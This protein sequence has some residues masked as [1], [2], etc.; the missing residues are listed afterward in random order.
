MYQPGTD[1]ALMLPGWFGPNS[2]TG[3]TCANVPRSA[4]V[5][6]VNQNMTTETGVIT[7]RPRQAQQREQRD[8]H[9]RQHRHVQP[10]GPRDDHVSGEVPAEGAEHQVGADDRD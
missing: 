3:L 6:Q 4:R 2:Q 7:G 8:H 10:V 5:A 9:H 1:P